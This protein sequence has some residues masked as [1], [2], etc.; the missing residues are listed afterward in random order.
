M[1]NI[2]KPAQFGKIPTL[3]LEVMRGLSLKTP[4]LQLNCLFNNYNVVIPRTIVFNNIPMLKA[5]TL[6][7]FAPIPT[8]RL[9]A[10]RGLD[11]VTPNFAT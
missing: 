9:E 7:Q 4:K 8:L 10:M 3:R 5:N 1:L 2:Q 6:V 11:L